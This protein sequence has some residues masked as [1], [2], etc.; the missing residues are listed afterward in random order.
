MTNPR[1][2]VLFDLDG[3]LVDPAGAITGG[4]ASAM[5]AAGLAVPPPG[6]LHRMVGPALVTSLGELGGVPD[7][8]IP[9]V[10]QHYRAGYR[11]TG[12]AASRPYPAMIETVTKLRSSGSLVAVATQK[13]E[14]LARELLK[15]QGMDALFHSLHGS[16]RDERKAAELDGKTTIIAEALSQHAGEFDAAVM[17]GDRMHDV[18]GAAAN[19]LR[20][21]GVS[22]GFGS[23]AELAGAGAEVIVD[24][25][26]ELIH[27]VHAFHRTPPGAARG[28]V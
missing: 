28:T 20:C 2:L 7:D 12:M 13:P 19:G 23:R 18:H 17:V 10:L 21:I 25:A 26:T 24:T 3:T 9:A 22:W 6:V 16:P 5:A 15:V 8:L 14:W 11:S 4:I 1:L 27:A